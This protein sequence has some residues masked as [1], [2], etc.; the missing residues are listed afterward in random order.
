MPSLP[1]TSQPEMPLEEQATTERSPTPTAH[2]LSAAVGLVLGGITIVTLSEM[3]PP[4]PGPVWLLLP[5]VAT[6]SLLVLLVIAIALHRRVGELATQWFVVGYAIAMLLWGSVLVG[7][8]TVA[9]V[10]DRIPST[11]GVAGV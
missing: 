2:A 8:Q 3:Y 10:R 9:A 11:L 7:E 5:A 6:T 1:R 4:R